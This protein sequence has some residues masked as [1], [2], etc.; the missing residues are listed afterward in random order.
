MSNTLSRKEIYN[1]NKKLK[2]KNQK[3]CNK[4]GKVKNI[5][6]FAFHSKKNG[7]RQSLCKKCLSLQRKIRNFKKKGNIE[8]AKQL[9]EQVE[10]N[11]R[12]VSFDDVT[13]SLEKSE[14][15]DK[16]EEPEN[17][18]VLH[19]NIISTPHDFQIYQDFMDSSTLSELR[20]KY[21]LTTKTIKEIISRMSKKHPVYHE[22][23]QNKQSKRHIAW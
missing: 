10:A 22:L 8:K 6:D 17:E 18:E 4:C 13:D 1:L 23:N 16:P 14:T 20:D 12:N 7:Q 21:R 3:F 9:E 2:A 11:R 5:D 19:E 15:D